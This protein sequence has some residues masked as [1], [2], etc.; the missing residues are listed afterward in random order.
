M[1]LLPQTAPA[2]H[3]EF[4][5]GN[6]PVKRTSNSKF[7]QVWTDMG[8]EQTINH[9]S[10]TKGRITGFSQKQGAVDRWYLTANESLVI[11]S[12]TEEMSGVQEAGSSS[13]HKEGSVSR[14]RRDDKDFNKLM[15]IIDRNMMNPFSLKVIIDD[16][17]LIA[18]RNIASGTVPSE[19]ITD[20]RRL[21]VISKTREL[22][23]KEIFSYE[24]SN[25]P[26][27]FSRPDSTLNKAV[28]SKLPEEIEKEAES[29]KS[30]RENNLSH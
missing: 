18:L 29:V 1:R 14:K 20:N 8:I 27:S 10:K 7:N 22:N 9:E 2:I 28:K 26:L 21:L 5:K 4:V 6:H 30:L 13:S 24:L 15:S 11:T 12:S 17:E 16:S 3:S 19:D 23:L 25:T